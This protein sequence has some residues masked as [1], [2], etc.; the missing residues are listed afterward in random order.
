[1]PADTDRRCR[2][3]TE[4]LLVTR[5]DG[6]LALVTQPDH[7][8]LAGWLAE[9]WGNEQ[10]V[11]PAPREALVTAATHH[12]DG[13]LELDGRADVQRRAAAP[14]AL[15]RAAADRNRRS[16]RPRRRVRL[17]P[18]PA[19]RRA[20]LDALQ[21]LL[22]GP[23]GGRG[24]RGRR[25]T[26]ELAQ[27]VVATQEARWMPASARGVGLPRAAQRVRRRHLARAT[28]CCRRSTCCRSPTG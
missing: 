21:R 20:G 25:R 23:L 13:W 8:A 1:M 17:R 27:E 15:H 18:R 12:D 14:R 16:L 10:F 9:H 24:R 19:R 11:V 28:R 4:P 2:S 5:R 7:A 3:R 26:T 6:R 22:H